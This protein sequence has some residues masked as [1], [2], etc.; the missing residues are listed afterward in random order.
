MN[1][2]GDAIIATVLTSWVCSDTVVRKMSIF[3]KTLLKYV[4]VKGHDVC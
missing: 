3:L 4:W 2:T 1:F